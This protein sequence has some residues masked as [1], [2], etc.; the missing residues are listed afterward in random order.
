MRKLNHL[1]FVALV[2]A[3]TACGARQTVEVPPQPLMPTAPPPAVV[4]A[5]SK[6][7]TPLDVRDDEVVWGTSEDSDDLVS[8]AEGEELGEPA[9]E[10]YTEE[11]EVVSESEETTPA[12]TSAA[13]A[14]EER[15]RLRRASELSV[16]TPAPVDDAEDYGGG[17]TGT[18]AAAAPSSPSA[19]GS[20]SSVEERNAPPVAENGTYYGEISPATGRAKTVHVEGYY[21][22]DGTYVR[23]H[24]RSAPRRRN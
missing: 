13:P 11:A 19:T 7:E 2:F 9:G 18:A 14:P 15:S 6:A 17:E 3:L 24:Y 1:L 12:V 10:S 4:A 20:R 21:R 8:E 22:R 16:A 5:T 23:G